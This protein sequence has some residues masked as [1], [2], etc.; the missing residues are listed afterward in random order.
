M[1]SFEIDL[2]IDRECFR[3]IA[4]VESRVR[5]DVSHVTDLDFVLRY[6]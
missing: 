6:S 5:V 4:V 1:H 2:N 3:N